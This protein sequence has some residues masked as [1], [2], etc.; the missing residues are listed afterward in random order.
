MV[1]GYSQVLDV[2]FS[3]SVA[4]VISNS[5]FRVILLAKLIRG[6]Q[7]FIIDAERALLH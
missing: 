7:A 1:C 3:E 5:R 6:L 2:D 4:L